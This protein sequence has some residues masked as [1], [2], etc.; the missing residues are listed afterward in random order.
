MKHQSFTV[1]D[2]ERSVV[3]GGDA[4]GSV[5]NIHQLNEQSLASLDLMQLVDELSKL[6]DAMLQE[7][8]TDDE[9]IAV[10]AVAQAKK[11]AESKN[12]SGV[13]HYLKIAGTWALDIATKIGVPIAVEALKKALQ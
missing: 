8:K 13:A 3:I 5:T 6:R 1:K 11:A 2:V 7:A 12:V 9:S 10:G 4:K